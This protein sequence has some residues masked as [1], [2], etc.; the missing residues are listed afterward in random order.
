MQHEEIWRVQLDNGEVR[1]MTLD[2]LD[3][4]FDQGIVHARSP[5][6]APGSMTWDR[7]GAV[8]GLD[9]EE[10]APSSAMTPSLSPM[11]IGESFPPPPRLPRDLLESLDDDALKPKRR[12]RVVVLA[13]ATTFALAAGGAFLVGKLGLSVNAH[14]ATTTPSTG[15][16]VKPSTAQAVTPPPAATN[17]TNDPNEKKAASLNEDQKKKL[18]E[19]DKAREQKAKEK[20]EE[21]ARSA[22]P[23]KRAPKGKAPFVSSGNKYDPLN[24]AL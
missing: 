18:L 16:E 14:A 19:A 9:Q 6:L 15:M 20:A 8:A 4:A 3:H 2:A 1:A 21:K 22:L 10:E 12:G 11:A 13:M 7:L 5:V 23:T 17:L 24:G